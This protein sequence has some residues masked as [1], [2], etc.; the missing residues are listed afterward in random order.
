MP[1]STVRFPV[2]LPDDVHA[3]LKALAEKNRRSLHNEILFALDQ[4]V[5]ANADLLAGLRAESQS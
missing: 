1:D 4:H 5:E 2:K 3:S